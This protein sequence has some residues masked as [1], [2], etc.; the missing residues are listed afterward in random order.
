MLTMYPI[1]SF[2]IL[3]IIKQQPTSSRCCRCG[4]AT[5]LH[6]SFRGCPLNEANQDTVRRSVRARTNVN[7]EAVCALDQISSNHSHI[8]T[9]PYYIFLKENEGT[10]QPEAAPATAANHVCASC[11][12]PNHQ[13]STF[14]DCPF[15]NRNVESEH[16]AQYRIACNV[17]FVPEQ[18]VGPNICYTPGSHTVVMYCH[19]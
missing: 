13:R 3:S 15:N 10:P 16:G 4:S 11:G 9:S 6:T 19:E 18:V 14:R 7:A 5:H 17:P 12:A 1:H 8:Y 2:L